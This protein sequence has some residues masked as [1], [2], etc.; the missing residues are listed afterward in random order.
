MT[1]CGGS[2]ITEPRKIQP[3][4]YIGRTMLPSA[5]HD[6]AVRAINTTSEPRMIKINTCLDTLT[7]VSE[8]DLLINVAL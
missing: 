4:V 5:H 6:I 1:V 2:F 7:P 8:A 3:G